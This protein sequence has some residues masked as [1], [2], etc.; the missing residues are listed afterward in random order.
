M[1]G[2]GSFDHLRVEIADG[3]ATVVLAPTHG[4]PVEPSFFTN[5][6]D[7]FTVLA[8]DPA[9]DAVVL[10]GEGEV[11]F[12]GTGAPRTARLVA[13]GLDATAG[14]MLTL[15]QIVSQMLSLR[16]PL[17][18]A[19][20]GRAPNIGSQIALLCDAAV[21]AEGATFGDHHV[22]AGIAAGDGGTMLWP[23]LLGMARARE[24]LLRGAVID[25]AEALELH[26]VSAVVERD[27]VVAEAADLARR[28]AE[29]PRLP[30]VATKLALNNVW[31]VM[32]L[33]SWDLALGL[34]TAGLQ[35]PQFV[36]TVSD[37]ARSA[38]AP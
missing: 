20:N 2:Y 35:T 9:A 6:C 38:E 34:E 15:Q 23:L 8:R 3:I 16:K 26:L 5:L 4:G 27:R 19:V 14:Q 10:T 32:S 29:L 30:Y 13:S 7:L 22:E 25:A 37:Q 17:V 18:A 21:A 11:F 28:L 24:I 36:A 1:I 12:A 31:R 33:V